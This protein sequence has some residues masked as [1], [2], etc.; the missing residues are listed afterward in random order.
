MA[1]VFDGMTGVLADVF[2]APV[3]ISGSVSATVAGLFREAVLEQE[4][5]D[6]RV[7]FGVTPS[8]KLRKGTVAA[9]VK[10]DV[11]APS[12]APGRSFTV[13][14]AFPSGS[15]ADDAFVVYALEEVR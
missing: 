4:G 8:V 3:T 11:V 7:F 5:A 13:L 1:S 2:G 14:Q 9:L 15:P 12:V 10:G 6:G